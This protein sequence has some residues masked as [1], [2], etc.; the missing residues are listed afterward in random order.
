L[1]EDAQRQPGDGGNEFTH[2]GLGKVIFLDF[3]SAHPNGPI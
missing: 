2:P 3:N 1:K